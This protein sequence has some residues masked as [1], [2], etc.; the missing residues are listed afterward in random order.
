[1]HLVVTNCSASIAVKSILHKVS[2]SISTGETV[3]IIGPSGSGK[4][5]LL[6]CI[7]GLQDH[8]GSI[9]FNAH[10]LDSIPPEQRNVGMVDQQLNLFPHM[11]V[12]ENIAYPLKIR[13]FK[14]ADI[15]EQVTAILEKFK[16]THTTKQLPQTLS[17]GEQQRVALARSVI[18]NPQ[19]L[20]LDEPFGGLD[21][22][23]RY[24]L[25]LWLK[26][27]LVQYAIPTLLVTHD[28]REAKAL[29]TRALI[30]LN[31]KVAAY[32]TWERLEQSP[33]EAVHSLLSKAL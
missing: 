14:K 19:L 32:D 13:K 30:L 31:G 29:S 6:R 9:E 16:I 18:Y 10:S 15:L 12:F 17:G 33:I 27:T 23:L 3:S 2:F 8:S 7:A 22:L 26:D 20:L 21:S 1:M 5:T 28:I 25:V 24:D 4:T 11:T